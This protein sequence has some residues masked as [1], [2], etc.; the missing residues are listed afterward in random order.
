MKPEAVD[1]KKPRHPFK[2]I[3]DN[4]LARATTGARL[5]GVL[6]GALDVGIDIHHSE[7]RFHGFSKEKVK[8]FFL[9][10]LT[11]HKIGLA[12]FF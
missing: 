1:G 11:Y 6:K 3:L 5:F 7:N 8:Y 10:F 9:C 2:A 4:G 12:W